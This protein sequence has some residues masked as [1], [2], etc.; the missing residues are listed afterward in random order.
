MRRALPASLATGRLI[1][2]EA[3][4]QHLKKKK[5]FFYLAVLDLSCAACGIDLLL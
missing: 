2:K 4:F 3:A 1:G 5:I